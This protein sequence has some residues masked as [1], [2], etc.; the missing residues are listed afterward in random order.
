MTDK[1]ARAA[2]LHP[3]YCARLEL[4][5]P[6]SHSS[7]PAQPGG[8]ATPQHDATRRKD[9][10]G[11]TC[12]PAPRDPP[13]GSNACAASYVTLP[14]RATRRR[15][16]HAARKGGAGTPWARPGY[17]NA[18]SE[19]HHRVDPD[20][21]RASRAS[22]VPFLP[23]APHC[24]PRGK[25]AECAARRVGHRPAATQPRVAGSLSPRSRALC[26]AAARSVRKLRV[27]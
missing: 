9:C 21:S 3:P 20:W 12:L 26:H 14:L 4:V 19:C 1:A 6:L 7:G 27:F 11:C 8:S 13:G 16:R 5:C 22:R 17:G 23:T 2:A 25:C 24:A 10:L 15:G 18:V